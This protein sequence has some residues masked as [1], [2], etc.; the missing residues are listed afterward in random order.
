MA[1]C[2]AVSTLED[3]AKK[4]LLHKL[5]TNEEFCCQMD[6]FYSFIKKLEVSDLEVSDV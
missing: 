4:L 2:A 6:F 1:A 3:I 5:L